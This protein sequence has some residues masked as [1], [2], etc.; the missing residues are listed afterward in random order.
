MSQILVVDDN[1][2]NLRYIARELGG[3]H[4]VRLAKNGAQ[5]LSMLGKLSPDLVLMEINLPGADGFR[6]MGEMRGSPGLSRTPFIL[7]SDSRDQD[8]ESRALAEGAVDYLAKP[9]ERRLLRHRVELHLRLSLYQTGLEQTIRDLEDIIVTSFSELVECRDENAG[10][11]VQ[12]AKIYTS[13]LGQALLDRGLYQGELDGRGLGLLSRAAPLFDIG[14]IGI[15]DLLLMKKGQLT[16]EEYEKVKMH[17]V[18]GAEVLKAIYES[19]P[20]Q[21]YLQYAITIAEG[22]HERYD[23]RGY[24]RGLSGDRI[25]LSNR[26]MGVVNVYDSL[27]TDKTFRPAYTHSEACEI[28]ISG[29]GTVFDPGV[30]DVF[31]EISPRFAEVR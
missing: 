18:I 19:T 9:V 8:L 21:T 14:K 24:P 25:D 11:H 12:R 17:T 26:I 5:A 16:F 4:D 29:R 30:I 13:L 31:S 10:G 27:V 3:A 2:E 23:G 15:S 7:L 20:S 6:T 28:V 1:L 22:H